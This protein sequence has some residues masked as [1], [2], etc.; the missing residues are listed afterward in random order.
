MGIVGNI[1]RAAGLTTRKIAVAQA[2]ASTSTSVAAIATGLASIDTGGAQ[3]CVANSSSA[4]ISSV[5]GPSVATIVSISGGTVNA[6]V[7]RLLTTP[8]Y[9]TQG[10]NVNCTAIGH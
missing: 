6:I 5:A 8:A 3:V 10:L 4:A 7:T 1:P 2:A 9:D